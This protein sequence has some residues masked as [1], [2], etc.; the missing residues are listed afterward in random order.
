MPP[1]CRRR[2]SNPSRA[3]SPAWLA[4]R[5]PLDRSRA[6]T[7]SKAKGRCGWFQARD[8]FGG[9]LRGFIQR[10]RPQRCPYGLCAGKSDGNMSL[11]GSAEL[12]WNHH[13]GVSP[14]AHRIRQICGVLHNDHLHEPGWPRK[15]KAEL[16]VGLSR[17]SGPKDVTAGGRYPLRIVWLKQSATRGCPRCPQPRHLPKSKNQNPYRTRDKIA[18]NRRPVRAASTARLSGEGG[19]HPVGLRGRALPDWIDQ[20]VTT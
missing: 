9:R 20:R 19:Q 1:P 15:P 4:L 8:G 13:E 3:T 17:E 7:Y 11:V 2:R 5:P 18:R 6:R 12:E 10:I 14:D 16:S